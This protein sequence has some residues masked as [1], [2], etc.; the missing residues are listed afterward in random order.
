MKLRPFELALVIIFIV[1][2][3][4]ALLLLSTFQ[5]SQSSDGPLI[6]EVTIW[7]TLDREGI[8]TI[9]DELAVSNEAYDKVRYRQLDSR[10]FEQ[11]LTNALADGTGPDIMLISHEQIVDLRR[12]IA[13]I[14]YDS[15]PIRDIR[16]SYVDGAEIFALSDGLYAYPIAVDPLMM[17]WN[18][19][20]L[21]NEGF[22]TPPRTWE[23]LVNTYVPRL[24][25]RDFD[26]SITRSALAFGEFDNVTNAFGIMSMLLIQSGSEGIEEVG[27]FYEINLNRA[28]SGGQPLT[29][30]LDF[31]TR[32]ARPNNALYSW[33]RTFTSDRLSFLAGDLALY[34]GYG[35]ESVDIE[36]ANP[37]LNF[38]IAEVPQGATASVRRTYGQFYGAALVRNTDNVTGASVVLSTLAGQAIAERIA[39]E[40]QMAPVYRNSLAAGSNGTYE[41]EYYRSAAVAFGWLNPART[42]TDIIFATAVREVIENRSSESSAASD[43]VDRL[44]LEYN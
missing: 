24:T 32:F 12:R 13:P 10:S 41:R 37:N 29:T 7:G 42:S 2:S 4:V 28:V 1:L 3:A 27:T 6:G 36:R 8:D 39:R 9:L 33:N 15:F 26:R 11:T 22:L 19:D 16:S 35:S 30:A 38:D 43:L 17:Y 40:N 44:E 20:L 5:S 34:F 14:S 21:T 25:T 18:R 23:D 31:Y